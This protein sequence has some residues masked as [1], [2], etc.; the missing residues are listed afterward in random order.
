MSETKSTIHDLDHETMAKI[1][2]SY[3]KKIALLAQRGEPLSTRL[4]KSY[5]YMYDHQ[6]DPKANFEFREIF[7]DW[8]KQ[9]LETTSR[10]EM[11]RKFGYLVDGEDPSGEQTIVTL[12]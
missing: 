4:K 7:K 5:E 6:E 1:V 8:M 10:L 2:R 3:S 12:Q 11:A 9:H